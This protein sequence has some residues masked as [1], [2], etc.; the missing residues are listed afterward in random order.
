MFT[1]CFLHSPEENLINLQFLGIMGGQSLVPSLH[2]LPDHKLITYV[3]TLHSLS[4]V[5][6]VFCRCC[7]AFLTWIAKT[8]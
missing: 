2:D 5:S 3:H 6:T 1:F 4:F 8:E 7:I